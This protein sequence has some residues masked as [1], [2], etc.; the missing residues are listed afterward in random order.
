M[1]RSRGT[2][3]YI[4]LPINTPVCS[5]RL[6]TTYTHIFCLCPKAPSSTACIHSLS[7]LLCP[8]RGVLPTVVSWILLLQ[9]HFTTYFVASS[10]SVLNSH[11]WPSSILLTVFNLFPPGTS[12]AVGLARDRTDI[13]PSVWTFSWKMEEIP[14]KDKTVLENTSAKN[15]KEKVLMCAKCYSQ[16]Y[17]N[18]SL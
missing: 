11:P 5:C 14:L 10:G 8:L 15:Q 16:V 17:P 13:V 3:N 4:K 9:V 18:Y 12:T 7:H 6:T 2:D 1:I